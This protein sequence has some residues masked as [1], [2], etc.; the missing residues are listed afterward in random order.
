MDVKQAVKAA[1]DFVVELMSEEGIMNLGLEEVVHDDA[2]GVWGITV[3]FS[4][5]WNRSAL[6]NALSIRTPSGRDYRVV[7]ISEKDGKVLSF[8][9]RDVQ[10]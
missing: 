9:Q 10:E 3:G 7:K 2:E 1:K 5:P 4:R 6:E 8:K